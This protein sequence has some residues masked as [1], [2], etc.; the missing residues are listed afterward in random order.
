MTQADA[1]FLENHYE[2]VCIPLRRE[3]GLQSVDADPFW[4]ILARN[5][6]QRYPKPFMGETLALR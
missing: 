1:D 2:S 3:L 4:R 5:F 6:E